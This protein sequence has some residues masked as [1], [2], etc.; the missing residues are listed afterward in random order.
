MAPSKPELELYDLDN[1]PH[2]IHNLADDPKYAGTKS[3]LLAEINRWRE[4]VKDVGVTEE[5]R[6]GGWSSEYPTKSLEEWQGILNQWE[7]AV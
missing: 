4:E 6:R 5:F 1:D 3:E 7:Q 2:E